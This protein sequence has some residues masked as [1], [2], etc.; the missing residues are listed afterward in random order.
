LDFTDLILEKSKEF[1]GNYD[2]WYENS[3]NHFV[4]HHSCWKWFKWASLGFIHY[5]SYVGS[6]FCVPFPQKLWRMFLIVKSLIW[7]NWLL[8]VGRGKPWVWQS[9][10]LTGTRFPH[11]ESEGNDE[12]TLKTCFS[13]IGSGSQYG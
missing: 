9:T 10:N 1:S 7:S 5:V 11:L 13:L 8:K 6:C 4:L 12:M 3:R 2:L